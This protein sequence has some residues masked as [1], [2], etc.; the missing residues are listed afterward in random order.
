VQVSGSAHLIL[1]T[2]QALRAG[3]ATKDRRARQELVFRM[4]AQLLGFRFI[5]RDDGRFL[6]VSYSLQVF[7][8][9]PKDIQQAR[10]LLVAYTY[11]RMAP[12]SHTSKT[13]PHPNFNAIL[14]SL[15]KRTSSDCA[16]YEST[17]STHR[18][19]IIII[20]IA[21]GVVVSAI[22]S[23]LYVRSCRSKAAKQRA[24]V[25]QQRMK[26]NDGWQTTMANETRYGATNDVPP[27][28]EP[29]RPE[30]VARM[31]ENWR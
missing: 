16:Y 4:K 10:P 12:I 7:F 11:T 24:T 25:L 3:R 28:Y 1:R 6:T 18:L 21:V 9:S 5:Y 30:R 20:I 23:L 14:T 26:L 27:P 17:C 19:A 29:R 8:R 22:L 2:A 31:G 13:F 15:Q